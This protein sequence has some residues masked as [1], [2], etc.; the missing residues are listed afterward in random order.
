MKYSQTQGSNAMKGITTQNSNIL[1]QLSNIQKLP[2]SIKYG[3][4][5]LN[6]SIIREICSVKGCIYILHENNILSILNTMSNSINE[7]NFFQKQSI[8][9]HG[10]INCKEHLFII[11]KVQEKKELYLRLWKYEVDLFKQYFQNEVLSLNSFIEYDEINFLFITKDTMD[12]YKIWNFDGAEIFLLYSLSNIDIIEIRTTSELLL[13]I[14]SVEIYNISNLKLE[15]KD[16]RTG[17]IVV[18]FNLSL[19]TSQALEVLEIVNT[20]LIINQQNSNP[21]VIDLY[22]L[23]SNYFENV[24]KSE[25][26]FIT[27]EEQNCLMIVNLDKIHIVDLISCSIKKTIFG[28]L[29]EISMKNIFTCKKTS[30]IYIYWRNKGIDNTKDYVYSDG[31][32]IEE[33]LSENSSM[34]SPISKTEIKSKKLTS[35]VKLNTQVILS[36]RSSYKKF[37]SEDLL[38]GEFEVISMLDFSSIWKLSST[39]AKV[40][41][42]E[43]SKYY[44][45]QDVNCFSFLPKQN[46]IV[47]FTNEHNVLY[48]Y[49]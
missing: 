20:N 46:L 13:V 40:S 47:G 32:M 22:T 44:N 28:C 9:A 2:R 38:Y 14:K 15:I 12:T 3:Y 23:N 39:S 16:I 45:T 36:E 43:N 21:K 30:K 48:L 5:D 24:F 17:E 37:E 7:L 10:L 18:L 42:F 41:F 49:N 19:N 34:K 6:K 1:S 35:N 8:T 31:K 4:L 33:H 25:S 27:L 29:N 26:K 11:S